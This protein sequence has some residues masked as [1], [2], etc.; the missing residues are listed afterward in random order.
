[1]TAPFPAAP[2]VVSGAAGGLGAATARALAASGV[3][4]LLLDRDA[5]DEL[6]AALAREGTECLAVAL[7]LRDEASILRA[8]DVGERAFGPVAHL[9]HCAAVL[10]M[11]PIR[12]LAADEFRDVLDVNVVGAFL[13]A[14]AVARSASPSGGSIVLVS[15]TGG[16]VSG[17]DSVA[18]GSSKHALHGVM[19]GLARAVGPAG[20]RVN[21]VCP[22][23]VDTP[24][25]GRE[26]ARDWAVRFQGANAAAKLESDRAASLLG[27]LPTADEVAAL[28][29][30]LLSQA[31]RAVTGQIYTAWG[32]PVALG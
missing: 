31:T 26:V 24:L 16:I 22:G 12:E 9:V 7:E 14:R 28:C 29:V 27:E 11:S 10:R 3:P 5:P 4:L 21:V 30:F 1:M 2:V 20:V 15:S 19:Q 23:T 25:F 32:A 6:A 17:A 8:L 13:L 18:Y